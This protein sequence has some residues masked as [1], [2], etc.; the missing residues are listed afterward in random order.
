[1]NLL[2]KRGS[3]KCKGPEGEGI[4]HVP[5]YNEV[6][7][8]NGEDTENV[9]KTRPLRLRC[10]V[11]LSPLGLPEGKKYQREQE[12][13]NPG[14]VEGECTPAALTSPPTQPMAATGMAM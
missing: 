4:R 11:G 8:P 12:T 10:P 13:R 7:L 2:Q 3:P 9:L 14:P 1:M 6:I 5:P